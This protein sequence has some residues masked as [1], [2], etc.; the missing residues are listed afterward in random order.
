[1]LVKLTTAVVNF[2]NIFPAPFAPKL[3]DK[4][5]TVSREKLRITLSYKKGA[6]KMLVKLTPRPRYS[7]DV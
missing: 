1:M 7:S 3:F 2:T 5:Q 6:R 4:S